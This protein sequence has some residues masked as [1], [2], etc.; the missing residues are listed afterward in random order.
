M[1][2]PRRNPEHV[3][4]EGKLIME[5]RKALRLS[6]DALGRMVGFSQ[7]RV[8]AVEGGQTTTGE[9]ISPRID[10]Y[11][12]MALVLGMKAQDFIDAAAGPYPAEQRRRLLA[13][14]TELKLRST[15]VGIEQIGPEA[16]EVDQVIPLIGLVMSMCSEDTWIAALKYHGYPPEPP[17]TR[18]KPRAS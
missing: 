8:S 9:R 5:R 15:A 1:R 12:R 16:L 6:Q 11:A 3:P 17:T 10:T 7:A 2:L 14:A 18:T 4:V 13:I